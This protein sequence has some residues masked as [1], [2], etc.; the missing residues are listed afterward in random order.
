MR[1]TTGSLIECS[2]PHDRASESL[3]GAWGSTP[4]EFPVPTSNFP[5]LTGGNSLFRKTLLRSNNAERS[6]W[7]G[8]FSRSHRG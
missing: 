4:V 5:V 7:H 2:I 8:G 1:P 3:P 6:R